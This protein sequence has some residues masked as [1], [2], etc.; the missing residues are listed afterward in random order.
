[1]ALALVA[2]VA[3][4]ASGCGGGPSK[5][6]LARERASYV[7]PLQQAIQ[8]RDLRAVKREAGERE[9]KCRKRIGGFVSAL[10]D[11]DSVLNVGVTLNSYSDELG[12]VRIQYDRVGGGAGLDSDCAFAA[13]IAET[14]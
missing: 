14:H 4:V 5:E 12:R 2:L 10:R 11:L 6:T 13:S 7:L 3:L 9:S 8:A 1:V